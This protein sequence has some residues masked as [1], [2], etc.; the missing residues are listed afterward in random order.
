MLMFSNAL[1]THRIVNNIRIAEAISQLV[2]FIFG[3]L[4]K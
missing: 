3:G 1:F 4:Q 2:F